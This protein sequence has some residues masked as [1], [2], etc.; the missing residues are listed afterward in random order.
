MTWVGQSS[1]C[2]RVC[3]RCEES[4]RLAGARLQERTFFRVRGVQFILLFFVYFFFFF[5]VGKN[6]HKRS[7]HNREAHYFHPYI[8]ALFPILVRAHQ[9]L[10]SGRSTVIAAD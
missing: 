1:K 3:E 7:W 8:A 2:V 9:P 5:S 6:A 10:S 4:W